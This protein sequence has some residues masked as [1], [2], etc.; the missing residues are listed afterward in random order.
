ML[1]SKQSSA[2]RNRHFVACNN[3]LKKG[4]KQL[5]E[6]DKEGSHYDVISLWFNIRLIHSNRDD[7]RNR[8]PSIGLFSTMRNTSW[9]FISTFIL[10]LEHLTEPPSRQYFRR[11]G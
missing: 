1:C 7:N 2:H 11:G 6:L 5:D 4:K 8:K 9:V 3:K 10:S